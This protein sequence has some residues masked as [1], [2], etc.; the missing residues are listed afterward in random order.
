MFNIFRT[1]GL[2]TGMFVFLVLAWRHLAGELRKVE[3]IVAESNSRRP[4]LV[5]A[6]TFNHEVDML[7]LRLNHSY[8]HV[9][10]FIIVE[11]QQ[12]FTG[13]PK[14]LYFDLHKSRFQPY[15]DKIRRFINSEQ[16]DLRRISESESF[17]RENRQRNYLQEVARTL[18]L[19]DNDL[20][21]QTDVDEIVDYTAPTLLEF[22]K[23]W[24]R[25]GVVYMINDMYYY[26]DE[27]YKGTWWK[28]FFMTYQ[29]F[30]KRNLNRL[31]VYCDF[32]FKTRVKT[33]W[34]LSYF[35]G[36]E[37]VHQKLFSNAHTGQQKYANLTYIRNRIKD[38]SLLWKPRAKGKRLPRSANPYPPPRLDHIW[39]WT[40]SALN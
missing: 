15:Q 35:G 21:F 10:L 17:R 6:L 5:E 8:P 9:D 28:S 12:T 11:S 32:P 27:C 16:M 20:I 13:Q 31:R 19:N 25:R 40:N 1:N 39:N 24:D 30:L 2:L 7:E 18:N 36:P 14:P 37:V 29:E 23:S 22:L 38:C 33:G 3:S 26:D 4:L 34:H